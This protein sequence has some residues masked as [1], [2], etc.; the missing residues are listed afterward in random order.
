MKRLQEN[1]SRQARK[2]T[3]F[4]NSPNLGALCVPGSV[5]PAKAGIQRRSGAGFAGDNSY[6]SILLRRGYLVFEQNLFSFFRRLDERQAYF[7]RRHA[8]GTRMTDRFIENDGVIK[9]H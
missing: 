4:L 7:Q 3:P 9:F 1:V 2:E 5:I 8:P 6:S